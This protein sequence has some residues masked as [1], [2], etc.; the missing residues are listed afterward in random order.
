MTDCD[1]QP[2]VGGRVLGLK[3]TEASRQLY[4]RVSGRKPLL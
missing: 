4:K 3:F 1:E 2:C